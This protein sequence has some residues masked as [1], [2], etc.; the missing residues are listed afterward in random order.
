[1]A[2]L[3][4]FA[5]ACKEESSGAE[6][7]LEEQKALLSAF[8]KGSGSLRIGANPE[9]ELSTESSA[10]A[11][12]L[13]L[14]FVKIYGAKCRFA[15]TRGMGFRK[16][17]KYHV[18]VQDPDPILQDLQVDF[19]SSTI[20][21]LVKNE[22]TREAYLTG[23]FLSGGSVNDPSS[24]NYHLEI[25]VEDMVY[26]KKLCHLINRIQ[27]RRFNAKIAARRKEYIVYLKRAEEIVDFIVLMKASECCLRFE[28][29]RIGREYANIGNRLVNLDAAN[30]MK[31][32]AAAERQIKEIRFFEDKGFPAHVS[33]KL[34]HLAKLRLNHPD[35]SLEELAELLSEELATTISK[36]NVNHLFRSLHA[37][38]E[39]ETPRDE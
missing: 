4:S 23:A 31:T 34:R 8:L 6:R 13:Y 22:E 18:L 3:V 26:A 30:M 1:M 15:Y 37:L 17:T 9:I 28:D 21:P 24:S 29:I 25:A 5:M 38:Y 20:P 16:K 39:E 7:T 32:S 14:S 12:M 11:K 33:P 2:E 19:F 10:I 27:S 35:A 36:S